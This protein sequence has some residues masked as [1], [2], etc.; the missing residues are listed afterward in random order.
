MNK[1]FKPETIDK[2]KSLRES[3]RPVK[4]IMSAC[5]ASES[6]VIRHTKKKSWKLNNT[7]NEML[8][9]ECPNCNFRCNCNSQPCSCCY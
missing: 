2:M 7:D 8:F 1:K 3:G 5:K 6:T 9:H 4:Y